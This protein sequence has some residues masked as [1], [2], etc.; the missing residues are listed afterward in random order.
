M[1]IRSRRQQFALLVQILQ[2]EQKLAPKSKSN[3][4]YMAARSGDGKIVSVGILWAIVRLH[5]KA[6]EVGKGTS[7]VGEEVGKSASQGRAAGE[8]KQNC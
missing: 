2:H 4:L 3:E 1:L 6:G 7:Q 5:H 8:S